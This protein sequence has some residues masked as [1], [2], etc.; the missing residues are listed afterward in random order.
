MQVRDVLRAALLSAAA[1]H[2]W[3]VSRFRKLIL[4]LTLALLIAAC[5]LVI[6]GKSVAIVLGVAV[7]VTA[8]AALWPLLTARPKPPAPSPPELRLPGGVVDRPAE[9]AQVVAAL[10]KAM[11]GTVGITTALQGAGGFGKTTLARMAC[12]DSRVRRHF[13]GR[14]YFVTIGRDIRDAAA[15]AAKVNEV[16][17]LIAGEE[18]AF[19]DPGLAGHRLGSLLETGP[20][21]LLVLDDVWEHGQLAPFTQGGKACSRL[22][23][24]RIPSLVDEDAV[25]VRVDQMSLEQSRSLLTYGLPRLDQTVTDALLAATGRWPLLI[26]LANKILSNAAKAHHDVS[27]AARALSARLSES[28]PAAVDDL[29]ATAGVDTSRPEQRAK[30]VRATIEASMSLLSAADTRRLEE[31]AVFAEDEVIP[32][33]LIARLW[34]GTAGL[35]SLETSQTC[36]R[37][38][39]LALV[40]LHTT[41]GQPGGLVMHDVVRDFLRGELGHDNLSRLN[42]KLLD[43][44]AGA[45]PAASPVSAGAPHKPDPWWELSDAD[46]YLWDH[47]IEHLI[48]AGRHGE[49]DTVAGDLRWAGT[50]LR[51]SGPAA[52]AADLSLVGTPRAER[53]AARLAQAAHLLARTDPAGA[54]VDVLCSRLRDDPAWAPQVAALRGS[55]G[56]PRLASRWPMPDLADMAFRRAFTGHDGPVNAVTWAPDGTWLATAGSDGSVRIWDTAAGTPRAVLTGHHG[57]VRAAAAAPDG[58]WLA[59]GGSDGAIR[60]WDTR[61]LVHKATLTA[62]DPGA[63]K[64]V[65]IAPDGTWL[66]SAG[67]HGRRVR[68]W[69]TATGTL[70]NTLT[71]EYGS[72]DVVAIAP[73]GTWLATAGGTHG[74][75]R[76]WDAATGDLT[77]ALPGNRGI[78][79]SVAIAPDGRWLAAG[80]DKGTVQL[81]DT[82]TGTLRMTLEG[83]HCPVH[84]VA[85]APDGTW[86]AAGDGAGAVRIWDVA[87]GE[88]KATLTGHRGAVRSVAAAPEGGWLATSGDE[89]TVRLWDV[90]A[91]AEK[92]VPAPNHGVFTSM[93]VAPGGTW[94]ATAGSDGAVRIWDTATGAPRTD[95]AC[96]TGWAG[97]L[98]A[99]PDATWLATGGGGRTGHGDAVARIWDVATGALKA[100]LTGHS[101]LIRSI[102]VAPDGTWLATTGTDATVRI[103]DAATGEHRIT[104]T[105]YYGWVEAAAIEPDGTWLAIA[106]GKGTVRI[107]DP[108]TGRVRTTLKDQDPWVEAVA[109]APG[110]TW[111][112]TKSGA[113]TVRIWDTATGVPR[114]TLGEHCGPVSAMAIS[115]DG[116]WLATTSNDGMIR[117][118]DAAGGTQKITLTGHHGPVNGLAVRPDGTRLASIGSDRTIRVWDPA[119]GKTEAMMR[120]DSALSACAWAGND[121]LAVKGAAGIYMFDFL[122]ADSHAESP[123]SAR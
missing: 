6:A 15:I 108:A 13:G 82:A 99:A 43:A 69:D 7:V 27:E 34:D 29:L 41:D 77:A 112:A 122:T 51:R 18:A 121:G 78:V 23:T 118:W 96:G 9:V 81:L 102:A 39:D 73:D 64:S 5:V 26:R 114:T 3:L 109:I 100:T 42:G 92:S 90:A 56:R 98:A 10:T 71:A 75:V 4:G 116:T 62:N 48:D 105:G 12:A 76:R 33:A 54:V 35:S 83:R 50:R 74:T 117:I 28:G 119:T 1:L 87:T 49:A 85:I 95:L 89:G 97:A 84:A 88:R 36:H 113:G 58:T 20:R 32:C 47:L 120:V 103:W 2:R 94:L 8:A 22:V 59:T 107:C 44:A 86:L 79:L 45:L 111:L 21:R 123:A 93:A 104:L 70:T 38:A 67:G 72:A 55:G 91:D 53:L 60:V 24:T 11:A 16:I 14:V 65:A 25:S 37:L 115:A 63:I 110:G 61:A 40:T 19:T 57:P 30:A 66:A 101:G 52:L 106:G 17:W 68:T 31:L 80:G 46:G